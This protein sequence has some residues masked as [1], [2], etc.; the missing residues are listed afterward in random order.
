M[1]VFSRVLIDSRRR[2][3]ARVLASLE[4]QHAVIARALDPDSLMRDG[5][6]PRS[7]WRLDPGRRG[8]P[9]RLYIVSEK[10]PDMSVLCEQFGVESGDI[11][12][13]SYDLFLSRLTCG[14]EWGFRL[15]ANPTKSIAS[16]DLSI[17]G[18][19]TGL[20]S[21]DDQLEWLY[22][23]ARESGFHLPINRLEMPE[24]VVRESRKINFV[25]R[26]STVTLSSAVY[27]GVLAVDDPE[28]LRNA[29]VSGIGR[30]KGYGFGLLTLVPLVKNSKQGD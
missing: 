9:C 15:K 12:T 17:R 6:A 30:A 24:V 3:A 27:E 13:C 5:V 11:A 4:R 25:R 16:G 2:S 10:T 19:R 26:N 14:Q 29:L 28:L 8:H 22:R 23:K 7:L 20:L 1:T 21:Y 18:K